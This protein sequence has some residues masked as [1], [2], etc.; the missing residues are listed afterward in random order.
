MRM[1]NDALNAVIVSI[2]N[3]TNDIAVTVTTLRNEL[4]GGEPPSQAQLDA[5]SAIAVRL[6]GIAADPSNPVPG[7]TTSAA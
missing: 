5:L 7:T 4:S 1:P 2:N 6:E 3:A